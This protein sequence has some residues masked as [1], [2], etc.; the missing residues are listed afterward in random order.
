MAKK[1]LLDLDLKGKRV[2]LRSEF[3]VPIKDGTVGDDNRIQAELPTIQY[4]LE[5]GAGLIIMSHLGRPDGKPVDEMSLKPVADYL[6]QLLSREVL[7][8]PYGD[9]E[10]IQAAADAI[11][12]GQIAMLEN[13]RFW[14]EE[15]QNDEDFSRYLATLGDIYVNDAFG[16]A[17]RAHCSTEGVGHFL[18]ASAGFLMEKEI[19]FLQEAVDNPKRPFVVIM[20][21]SKVS[22]KIALIE[23]LAGKA[24]YMLFGGAMANTLLAAQGY[25]MGDS[26]I[27]SDKLD[28]SR[29]MMER[30]AK[31]TCTIVYPEDLVIADAFSEDANKKTVPMDQVPEGWMALDI[32]EATVK[33]WTEIFANAGT[34]IWNGPLGVYEME[35]FAIGSTGVANAMAA[36]SAM[37]IV[38]GGDAVAAVMQAGCGERM[39]HLS[40]GGGA[41]LELLEGKKLPGIEI[42]QDK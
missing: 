3:N 29:E 9:R 27:E 12:P 23:N 4:I 2:L 6:S 1:T 24:D 25:S 31:G 21:G 13:M 15:E 35:A 5:Q 10:S 38:G 34:I 32:G 26:K 20:G 36:S 37:T 11:L 8:I 16:A 14:P 41:S 33:A 42:L 39:S 17:H 22:D 40:T 19:T 30:V 7:L 18:P 28:I